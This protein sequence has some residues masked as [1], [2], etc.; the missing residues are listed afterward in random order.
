MMN[1]NSM[2]CGSASNGIVVTDLPVN[3]LEAMRDSIDAAIRG[4]KSQS[5]S[6]PSCPA[7]PSKVYREDPNKDDHIDAI[8]EAIASAERA[9]YE[10]C[11][12]DTEWVDHNVDIQLYDNND[13]NDDEDDDWDEDDEDDEDDDDYDPCDYCERGNCI[14]CRFENF[15]P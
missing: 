11:L 1:F 12:N 15:I 8:R 9:G 14:G 13:N 3:V 2:L 6:K 4:Q 10:I 5:C 7:H